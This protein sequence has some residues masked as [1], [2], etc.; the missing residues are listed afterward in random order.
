[1]KIAVLPNYVMCGWSSTK[2]EI[3]KETQPYCSFRDE[4]LVMDGI[5]IKGRRREKNHNTGIP[6]ET[7]T[8]L[9]SIESKTLRFHNNR[10]RQQHPMPLS[11]R[12]TSHLYQRSITQQKLWQ[13]ESFQYSK[14]LSNLTHKN[15]HNTLSCHPRDATSSLGLSIQKKQ[16][17]FHTF[18]IP[19]Y[20][21]SAIHMFTA[22]KLQ[23]N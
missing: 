14:N 1:M 21:S 7:T 17:T 2:C 15:S 11:K 20:N 16:L 18:L 9:Q 23:D 8:S 4:I 5:M 12:R 6:T 13:S 22:F 3:Q 10:Q 19:I